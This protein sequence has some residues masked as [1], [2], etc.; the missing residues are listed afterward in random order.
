MK[1][2]NAIR[3]SKDSTYVTRYVSSTDVYYNDDTNV[4]KLSP[5]CVY[6]CVYK[7]PQFFI[8]NI[9]LSTQL[10][11]SP[12]YANLFKTF[13][14]LLHILL[15]I[16]LNNS[17]YNISLLTVMS[18][19]LLRVNAACMHMTFPVVMFPGLQKLTETFCAIT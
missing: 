18:V 11:T 15:N 19:C 17:C 8:Y 7:T 10:Y 5:F 4:L 12:N 16:Y 9:T 2:L 6:Y 13:Y 3:P 1:Q 14:C